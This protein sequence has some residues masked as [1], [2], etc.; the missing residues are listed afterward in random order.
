MPLRRQV[1]LNNRWPK[2]TDGIFASPR[3]LI[4]GRHRLRRIKKP[5]KERAEWV[6]C[7]KETANHSP[8]PP[9]L[10]N[11]HKTQPD[12]PAV[13]PQREK[14]I[15]RPSVP[16]E[17][18]ERPPADAS[19]PPPDNEPRPTAE[20]LKIFEPP[21]KSA[22]EPA[23]QS[24]TPRVTIRAHGTRSPQSQRTGHSANKMNLAPII[25]PLTP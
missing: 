4:G 22:L 15:D 8:G 25:I 14:A 18:D 19:A 24:A 21:T 17:A 1:A 11:Q 5:T 10:G 3:V 13:E 16:S 9:G 7:A 12:L 6:P 20:R 2:G 23:R